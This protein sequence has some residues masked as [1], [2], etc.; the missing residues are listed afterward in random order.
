MHGNTEKRREGKKESR[1][2][3]GGG[4]ECHF[5][6]ITSY[7]RHLEEGCWK[8]RLGAWARATISLLLVMLE[9]SWLP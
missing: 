1:K 4:R 3:G 7:G 5:N 6:T 2:K 9:S 8:A